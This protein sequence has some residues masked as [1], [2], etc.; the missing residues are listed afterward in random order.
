MPP[1][2]NDSTYQNVA[3][4]APSW[5]AR[6]TFVVTFFVGFAGSTASSAE[7]ETRR[8]ND[9]SCC[10]QARECDT[11][12]RVSTRCIGCTTPGQ[13]VTSLLQVS[14]HS[15]EE[16][17][18][19]SNAT[20]LGDQIPPGSRAVFYLHGNRVENSEAASRGWA[21]YHRILDTVENAPP[22]HF[23]IWSWPS[24]RSGGIL[25]DVRT[26]AARMPYQAFLLA[27]FLHHLD[28][29]DV[30]LIGFSFGARLATGS[31]HLLGGGSLG[32]NSLDREA[33]SGPHHVSAV[34][35]AAAVDNDWILP[36][37]SHGQALEGNH[38]V[39]N[40]Y[41]C[42]DPILKRYRFISRCYNPVALGYTGLA[43]R[44]RLQEG[45]ERYD[46]ISV[47]CYVGCQHNLND[48]LCSSQVMQWTVETLGLR[49]DSAQ[50]DSQAAMATLD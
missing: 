3:I 18:I 9:S 45:A 40:L 1:P 21:V 20:M 34:L 39:M 30:G 38:H 43:G 19:E 13:D 27:S 8:E 42:C 4:S 11:V 28:E 44:S 26:K 16:G 23:I 12:W 25:N 33:G 17:W 37:R 2:S 47:A 14:K 6:L 31:M 49:D 5:F 10:I 29:S 41:N 36:G 35:Y 48:Y 46:E 50:P 24:E 32:G 22:M 7:T 15:A